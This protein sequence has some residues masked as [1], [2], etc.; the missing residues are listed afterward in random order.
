MPAREITLDLN[1]DM[2]LPIGVPLSASLGGAERISF[3]PT[4]QTV[5]KDFD[6]KLLPDP[7]PSAGHYYRSD[8]FSLARAGIPAFSIDQGHLFEGHD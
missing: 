6:L 4:I 3:W 5:A 7:D 1:Y 8:H 2:L